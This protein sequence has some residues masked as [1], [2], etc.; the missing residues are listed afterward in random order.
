MPLKK[1]SL[2]YIILLILSKFVKTEQ[3]KQYHMYRAFTV[4]KITKLVLL[5]SK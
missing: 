2:N 3:S 5:E 4:N 1:L